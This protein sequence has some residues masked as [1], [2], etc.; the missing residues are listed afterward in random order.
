MRVK[1]HS[2]SLTGSYVVLQDV[3]AQGPTE[4]GLVDVG[5]ENWCGSLCLGRRCTGVA[6]GDSSLPSWMAA[7]IWVEFLGFES[8]RTIPEREQERVL[9]F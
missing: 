9:L 8:N 7:E 4:L 6:E 1:W 3:K 2:S 5:S